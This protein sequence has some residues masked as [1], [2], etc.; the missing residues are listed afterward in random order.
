LTEERIADGES[1][2]RRSSLYTPLRNQNKLDRRAL[3]E[4]LLNGQGRRKRGAGTVR[5][6]IVSRMDL[7]GRGVRFIVMPAA[8][9]RVMLAPAA[10]HR[11]L[12]LGGS[13]RPQNGKQG[14]GAEE[15]YQS[16]GDGVACETN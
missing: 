6:A 13:G 1:P 10:C 7:N 11:A 16:P 3:R 8:V 4:T 14:R 12:R 5:S 9:P 15:K 2:L